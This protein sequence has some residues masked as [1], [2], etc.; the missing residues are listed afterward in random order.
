MVS[1]RNH[2]Q[3]FAVQ[4]SEPSTPKTPSKRS[5]STVTSSRAA[6]NHEQ[7]SR[8]PWSHTPSLLTLAWLGISL[9]LVVWDAF[10]VLARPHTMPGGKLQWP[11]YMPYELYGQV[12]Y[13]YGWPAWHAKN[14][15]TAAQSA[16]N[17]VETAGYAFYLYLVY[18]HGR[19]EDVQGTG[20]P[21]KQFVGKL[22]RS[23][24]VHGKTAAQALVVLY[25][26]ALMTLSKTVL[27]CMYSRAVETRTVSQLSQQGSTKHTAGLQT[28]A[29]TMCLHWSFF[30]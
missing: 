4:D 1:T 28:S 15:F 30:G 18:A 24:T 26:I 3:E 6:S 2:P 16:L 11:L 29:T 8:K 5:S 14:G 27:Y 20:A 23:R 9:P 17:V 10:Y 22:S 19:T 25:G 12:D 13:I 21:D 7:T